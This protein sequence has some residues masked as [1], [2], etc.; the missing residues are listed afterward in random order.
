MSA[1]LT[2][3][4]PPVHRSSVAY[5]ATVACARAFRWWSTSTP[6]GTFFFVF[7][8]CERGAMAFRQL[9]LDGR[10]LAANRG[11]RAGG[12]AVVAGVMALL[13]AR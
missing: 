1:W 6:S 2:L 9:A 7:P 11:A 4:R 10:E 5:V 13:V 3:V 8:L 12:D